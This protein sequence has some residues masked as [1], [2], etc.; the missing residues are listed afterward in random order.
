MT[1]IMPLPVAL[2]EAAE[3]ILYLLHCNFF[4][5]II[6]ADSKPVLKS[7]FNTEIIKI[8]T[9]KVSYHERKE[10]RDHYH[11]RCRWIYCHPDSR[12]HFAESG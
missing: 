7:G 11:K 10:K 3:M 9:D 12:K 5:S 2:K 4:C 6:R 8:V 1:K